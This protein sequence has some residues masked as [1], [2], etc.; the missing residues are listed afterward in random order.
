MDRIHRSQ[1]R[2]QKKRNRHNPLEETHRLC[3]TQ[4][5]KPNIHH[6]QPQ[7]QSI[8]KTTPKTRLQRQKLESGIP[9]NHPLNPPKRN[10]NLPPKP[11]PQKPQPQPSHQQLPTTKHNKKQLKVATSHQI[12][13]TSI[14]H[15]LII[16]LYKNMSKPNIIFSM[17]KS[18][19]VA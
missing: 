1:T 3:Q 15:K 12:H 8:H 4:Q 11:Q 10:N 7:Q 2:T 19:K 18:F 17:V 5:H 16:R 14:I 13:P 6:N 9:Q